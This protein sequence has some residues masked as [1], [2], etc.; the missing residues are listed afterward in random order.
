MSHQ[1][2]LN[3]FSNDPESLCSNR[4]Y[5][6]RLLAHKLTKP[7]GVLS[8][9]TSPV[10]MEL[11]AGEVI[12]AVCDGIDSRPAAGVGLEPTDAQGF[13]NAVVR[14][15]LNGNSEQ[16]DLRVSENGIRSVMVS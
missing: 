7:C 12:F 3:R 9:V 4:L 16:A 2:K 15:H 13:Q 1:V 10:V 6:L 8:V 5:V 11:K 14:F